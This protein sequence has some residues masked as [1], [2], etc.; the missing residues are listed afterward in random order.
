[1]EYYRTR[2]NAILS[3]NTTQTENLPWQ[4]NSYLQYCRQ[5]RRLAAAT[6]KA[7]H[8]DMT[9]F[10]EFVN[11]E[12][13]NIKAIEDISR[14]T[15]QHYIC[16]MN[17]TYRVKSVKRKIACLK[18][19]FSYLEAE[20]LIS[21]NPFLKMHLRMREPITLPTV[22]TLREVKKILGAVYSEHHSVSE[23]LHL[24]DIAVLEVFFATGLR[25]HELCNLKYSDLNLKQSAIRVMGKGKKER[26]IY[27]TN[28]EV[29]T[30]LS[31]Y[32]RLLKQMKMASNYLFLNK[33]GH[34][35]PTQAARNIVTKYTRLA[36]IDRNI[37]PH[38]FRHTFAT[39][40]LEEGVDIKY[41]QE[42]LGHSSISTTQIYLH[43][44][45]TSCKNI[46]N[47]KHPRKKLSFRNT[48]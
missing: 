34:Q 47:K 19:F 3:A 31:K 40:L 38:A 14:T 26:Y 8:I 29:L 2:E 45:A 17:E 1:M 41:I 48:I 30:A 42:F 9:Q 15:L 36:G 4:I 24:R 39:L 32:F 18:G 44:S 21:S 10:L 20:S 43:V 33:S 35:L 13:K 5:S 46:I 22:M 11:R 12:Y 16:E 27:I 37:T 6:L 7:Y 23:L 25:V 28:S